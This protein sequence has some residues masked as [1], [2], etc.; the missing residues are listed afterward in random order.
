M[1]FVDTNKS[2]VVSRYEGGVGKI[3]VGDLNMI[4]WRTLPLVPFFLLPL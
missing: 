2:Y 4:L 1:S 3:G